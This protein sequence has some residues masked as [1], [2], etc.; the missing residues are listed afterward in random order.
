[1][2]RP[3]REAVEMV[4]ECRV[5]PTGRLDD[6]ALLTPE[7]EAARLELLTLRC[8]HRSLPDLLQALARLPRHRSQGE[9][10]DAARAHHPVRLP[11]E[12]RVRRVASRPRRF[13]RYMPPSTQV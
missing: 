6:P 9:A 7:L 3:L 4:R 1:V 13:H 12:R 10:G 2:G 11:V 8:E 5:A